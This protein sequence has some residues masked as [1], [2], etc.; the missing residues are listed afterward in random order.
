M[1]CTSSTRRVRFAPSLASS[2]AAVIPHH[3]Y[4]EEDHKNEVRTAAAAAPAAVEQAPL[5]TEEDTLSSSSWYSHVDLQQLRDESL[6]RVQQL[7]LESGYAI[8]LQNCHQTPHIQ[9]QEYL[10]AYCALESKNEETLRGLELRLVS[11]GNGA[12][13]SPS[14]GHAHERSVAKKRH[15]QAILGLQSLLRKHHGNDDHDAIW[16][17][18][19][20][21]SRESSAAAKL[22]AMRMGRADSRVV[23]VGEDMSL[24][25]ELVAQHQQRKLQ[26]QQQRKRQLLRTSSISSE[27]SHS[28]T[29]STQLAVISPTTSPSNSYNRLA[30]LICLESTSQHSRRSSLGNK[31]IMMTLPIQSVV[32]GQC[33]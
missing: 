24:A 23:E 5:S 17:K 9:T 6:A 31:T 20:K 27:T 2:L 10:H 12:T 30:S 33:V 29:S 4:G 22:F 13:K 18:M 3:G 1:P 32:Y 26:E 21:C 19:A 8:L 11:S 7:W 25:Q 28:S 14:S 15:R 16:N